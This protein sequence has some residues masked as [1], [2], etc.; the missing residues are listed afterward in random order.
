MRAGET[1]DFCDVPATSSTQKAAPGL[2]SAP[3]DV[4]AT[5]EQEAEDDIEEASTAAV[6]AAVEAIGIRDDG[7]TV[8]ADDAA[9]GTDIMDG[10]GDVRRVRFVD[11]RGVDLDSVDDRRG[12]HDRNGSD[13]DYM[14][15]EE[16][17]EEHEEEEGGVG[18]AGREEVARILSERFLAGLEKG[19]D[20]RSVDEDERLDDLEQLSRDEVW[21][22][23]VPQ[24]HGMQAVRT[25]CC[26]S[27]TG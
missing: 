14:Q 20:Y 11:E 5:Q 4:S 10:A 24:K 6:T 8:G 18:G 23:K 12:G 13:P 1:I 16:E 26:P 7:G 3:T 2:H 15:E 17:E 25:C 21:Y 27:P 19:V 22:A 9:V